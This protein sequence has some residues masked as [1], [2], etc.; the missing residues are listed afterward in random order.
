LLTFAL[1]EDALI[2]KTKV[3]DWL[4]YLTTLNWLKGFVVFIRRGDMNKHK[5]LDPEKLSM[6]MYICHILKE[7]GF[8]FHYTHADIEGLLL[9]V[10]GADSFAYGWNA[11][12]NIFT[13]D[14]LY[15]VDGK[16]G[17]PPSPKYLSN[18]LFYKLRGDTDLSSLFN[19]GEVFNS[20]LSENEYDENLKEA[21]KRRD[22]DSY[23][24]TQ[25]RIFQCWSSLG[26]LEF[27]INEIN[28]IHER[29][30]LLYGKLQN[31]RTILN[32]LKNEE[33][34]L[35]YSDISNHISNLLISIDKFRQLI[36]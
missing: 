22:F 28:D 26:S 6:L 14:N 4:N 27:E 5:S 32:Q 17:R 24:T 36:D 13:S 3:D 25:T 15:R 11:K 1:D 33:I 10:S 19:F 20:V 2:S 12:G 7:N 35:P 18:K 16:Q 30:E 34:I 23:Y 9:S 21:I 31:A 29:V 8:E